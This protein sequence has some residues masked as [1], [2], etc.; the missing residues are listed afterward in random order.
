MIIQNENTLITIQTIPTESYAPA[1]FDLTLPAGET[2]SEFDFDLL[3]ITVDRPDQHT[4]IALLCEVSVCDK[5]CA[6]LNGSVL[7]VLQDWTIYHIDIDT[8]MLQATTAVETLLPN[9]NLYRIPDG[10]IVFGEITVTKLDPDFNVLWSFDGHDV[11]CPMEEGL[12][13][14]EL[15]EDRIK[16][17]DFNGDYYELGYGGN[18]ITYQK[19]ARRS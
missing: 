2:L 19:R 15:C 1:N 16:L 8:C 3:S 9:Y 10:Y 6:V 17:Y 4:L 14:I 11:F 13:P 12:K 5:D 18:L 7:S